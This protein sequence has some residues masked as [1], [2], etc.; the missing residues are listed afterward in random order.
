[1][2]L[3]KLRIIISFTGAKYRLSFHNRVAHNSFPKKKQNKTG[4]AYDCINFK[5]YDFSNSFHEEVNETWLSRYY[6]CIA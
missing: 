2:I 5:I 3:F 1:M 6:S 4:K